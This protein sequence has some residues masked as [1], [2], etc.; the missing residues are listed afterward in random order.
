MV[1]PWAVIEWL[2]VT[3]FSSGVARAQLRSTCSA[4]ALRR[5]SEAERIGP[6]PPL[7]DSWAAA[8]IGAASSAVAQTAVSR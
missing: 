3:S 5:R 2:V 6:E 1:R 8:N 4:L 7:D